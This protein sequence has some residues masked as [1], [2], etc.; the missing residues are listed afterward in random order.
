V[1]SARIDELRRE[2]ASRATVRSAHDLEAR[3][4]ELGRRKLEA[5]LAKA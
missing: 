3:A 2:L 1:D 5:L 4:L